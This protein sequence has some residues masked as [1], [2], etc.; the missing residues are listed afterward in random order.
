MT[1]AILLALSLACCPLGQAQVIAYD[2][3]D[4]KARGGWAVTRLGDWGNDLARESDGSA[5]FVR[6]NSWRALKSPVRRATVWVAVTMRMRGAIAGYCS[7][8]GAADTKS[9]FSEL[10]FNSGYGRTEGLWTNG[11][12]LVFTGIDCQKTQTFLQRYDLAEGRWSAWAGEGS[13]VDFRSTEP[14]VKDA[15]LSASA[16]SHIY[17]SKSSPQEVEILRLCVAATAED[18]LKPVPPGTPVVEL[19]PKPELPLP[20]GLVALAKS[21][22]LGDRVAFFGDSITW[23]GGFIDQMEHSLH[24]AAPAKHVALIRRGINGAKSTDIL[25]GV[26]DLFGQTQGLFASVLKSDQPDVVVIMVGINDIWHGNKGNSATQ[27]RAAMRSLARQVGKARLVLVSPT[28]IGE[29]KSEFEPRLLEASQIVRSVATEVGATFVD[30]HT[31]F[32]KELSTTKGLTYDGVHMTDAGNR[33]LADMIGAGIARALTP[34]D[35]A[36]AV[37]II[38]APAY[39]KL[40]KGELAI[41]KRSLVSVQDPR[42]ES[43]A[44]VLRTTLGKVSEPGTGTIVLKIDAKLAPEAYRVHVDKTVVLSGGSARGVAWACSSFEQLLR[45]GKVPRCV[46]EDKP[47]TEFRALMV[48][49]ARQWHPVAEVKPLIDLCYR[50]KVPFMQMHLTDDQSFTLPS[51]AFP[52]LATPG[53]SYTESELVDLQAYAKGRGVIVIPELEMPGHGGQMVSRMPELFRASPKHH[54][55]LNFANRACVDALKVLI[56]EVADLFPDSPYIHIGGDE[57]DLTYVHEMPDFQGAFVRE[58]VA[59]AHELYRKLLLEM[60][61]KVKSLGKTMMVWEGFG[62]GGSVPISKDIVVVA[63]ESSY[64]RPDALL[65][66]GFTVINASWRPLYVVNDRN[67]SPEEIYGWNVG[68]WGHFVDWM[69]SYGGIQVGPQPKL[70]GSMMCAWEQPSQREFDSLKHRLAAMSE[71]AW[72]PRARIG[73][74]D[75]WRRLQKITP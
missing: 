45:A 11:P 70:L 4:G 68:Y 31:A 32:I 13:T 30:A 54:A 48:D 33:L 36:P 59:N 15:P 46:I 49:L 9:Q 57:A 60:N 50:Y 53:R 62:P 66:D 3:F 19:S 34:L 58:G 40:L 71:R 65:Q 2:E 61:A 47:E 6:G 56:G 44:K 12:G 8:V 41:G 55:T 14:K 26:K 39:S 52:Q 74:A 24:R 17:L 63:Y 27:Y 35:P 37:E 38:P 42:L 69:P 7:V 25:N 1:K 67:W 18:A 73:F 64:Y 16:L 43:T 10:G 51:R 75:F 23:Q 20:E 5:F 21:L 22:R 28:V 29:T 72:H